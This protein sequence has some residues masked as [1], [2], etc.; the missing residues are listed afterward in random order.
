[1]TFESINSWWWP[2]VFIL[3]AGWL[4]TDAFRYLGVYFGGKLSE[5]SEVLV[6][7][8]AVATAL[9]AAVVGNLVFFPAGA[10]A[11]VSIFVRSG[12]FVAGFLLY[13]LSG[14]KVLVGIFFAEF[15][16]FAGIYLS[17]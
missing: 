12:A 14:K 1:M 6:I 13:V 8:R 16:L 4:A 11:N 10:L 15:V 2:Y 17:D 7:V 5:A 9:V 3:I